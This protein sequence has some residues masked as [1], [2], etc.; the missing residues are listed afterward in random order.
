MLFR[1]EPFRELTSTAAFPGLVTRATTMPIDV[2]RTPDAYLVQLDL[3]GVHHDSIEV[4]VKRNVLSVSAHL[5]R[6]DQ[7]TM[8]VLVSERPKGL[9]SRRLTL[10]EEIDAERIQADYI[11]G[12]LMIRLPI[13]EDAKPQRVHVSAHERVGESLSA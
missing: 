8:D 2:Y 4:Y 1:T 12:V 6:P 10:G 13:A 11:D 9:V 7:G 3:P 5:T